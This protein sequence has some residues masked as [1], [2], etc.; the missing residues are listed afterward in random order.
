MEFMSIIA[1]KFHLRGGLWGAVGE[2]NF[3]VIGYL[4]IGVFLVSWLGS[5]LI[6]KLRNYD[7]IEPE[8]E[9]AA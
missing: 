4:I 7:S 8:S 2:L 6:Y 9:M 3:E 1:D 5:T